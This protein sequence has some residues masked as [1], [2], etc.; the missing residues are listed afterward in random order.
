MSRPSIR[1]VN[2]R[3]PHPVSLTRRDFIQSSAIA[4]TGAVAA[5]V[6]SNGN[7]AAAP[8]ETAA[9][10]TSNAMPCGQIG[11]AK[12]S[13]LLLG[14]NLV[15]GGMHA[16]DLK[17]AGALFRAAAQLPRVE[18][19]ADVPP[20]CPAEVL[21][22][23]DFIGS[24]SAIIDWCVKHNASEF[25]VMTE[26]GV[27]HSLHKLAPEKQFYFVP[28]ENCNCSEC[29]YMKRN[30]LEKLA[31]CLR[32]LEPR[33]EVAPEMMERARLPIDRMLAVK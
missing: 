15:K 31:D 30:T 32:T 1:A 9:A 4:A 17:Y 22:M 26:S 13:R 12:I 16:R 7:T 8:A 25:I 11:K 33:V 24:T 28:N 14:G 6:S 18:L 29:P 10:S 2:Q 21:T 20:E 19:T 3:L 23:A 5:F 27:Q